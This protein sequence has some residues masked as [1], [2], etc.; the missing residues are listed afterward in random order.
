MYSDNTP[1]YATALKH[2]HFKYS[3]Y[4]CKLKNQK[5]LELLNTFSTVN[6]RRV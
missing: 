2:L 1:E 6:T 5:F 3:I 4:G